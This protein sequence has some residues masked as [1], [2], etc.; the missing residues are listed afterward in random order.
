MVIKASAA[1]EIRALVS[2]L[3]GTD[4]VQRE[5]AVARLAI[6]GSR[7]VDR[8][9]EAYRQTTDRRT[10]VAIL[11][12]LEAIGDH[13][14][15][16]VARQAIAAGGDVGV[17]A[18]GV[19]RSILPSPHG[20]AA[21]EA[22][23]TLIEAALDRRNEHRIR[24]AA[25]EALQDTPEDVRK[26]VAEAIQRDPDIGLREVARS[27]GNDAARD[28][29]RIGAV[30]SDA[31]EGHLPDD[32]Q[33]LREA[34][35]TRAA[36]APLNALQKLVESVRTKEGSG[37]GGWL[38]VRGSLHQALALRSSRVALYDLRESLERSSQPLPPAFLSALH[39]LGDA[40]CLEPLA[41]AWM[42]MPP[43]EE[44]YRHQLASAFRAIAKR[45]KVT[46]RHALSK[47]ITT[48]WPESS[49]LWK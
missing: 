26:R 43:T 33:A 18:A 48:R 31:L 27:A 12:T 36:S 24:L 2:A 22:L 34:L 25:V 10:H 44:R 32:P 7:A 5:T 47:R 46:R 40:A 13:R 23:D 41:G 15:A 38:L 4:D 19:L 45:Q 9:V 11:K 37:N 35:E 28:S 49:G 20:A 21:T 29:A 8:L 3:E 39:V 17:A 30:W 42:R 16:P 1:V 6:I 14:S